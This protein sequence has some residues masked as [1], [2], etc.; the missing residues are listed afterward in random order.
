MMCDDNDDSG[1]VKKVLKSRGIINPDDI[2]KFLNPSV[3]ENMPD[4]SVLAGM[5]VA[6]K[7]VA[8]AIINNEKIAIFGDYDVDGITSTAILI[9]YLRALGADPVW[10]LPSRDGE[11]YGLN[12]DSVEK[13]ASDG[14]RILITVDC[15]I[16]S[17]AEVAR[18]RE[19]GMKVVITDH[20]S[21]DKDLPDANAIVN[22]KQINDN[23]GLT[24]LAGVGVA[25][26]F[27]VALN[28]EIK[29][30]KPEIDINL[31][32]YLDL[33]AIGTI[34]DTCPLVGLNRAFVVTGLKIIESKKNIGIAALMQIS[35]AKSASA[36]TI[37]FALGPRINAAGRLADPAPA[38]ELLLTDNIGTAGVLAAELDRQ[39][40]SRKN[41]ESGIMMA[42]L[43]IAEAH[44]KDGKFSLFL[45]GDNW[46]GGVM[47]IIAG[48][49]KEKYNMP[50]CVATVQD[51]EIN[52]SGRSTESIDLGAIIHEALAAG[53]LTEGG[54]H[55]AAAGFSMPAN[56][57]NAF[58]EFLEKR[59]REITGN[60]NPKP[61]III[62]ARIDAG[63]A[64]LDL[65]REMAT[66]APFGQANPEP[67]LCLYGCELA[68]ATTM[69]NGSHIRGAVRTSN[70][71]N[72]NFV[73]FNMTTGPIG[74]FLLD[75]TNI[76]VKIM[77]AG[78]LT[79][80]EF[81]GRTTAQFMLE[82]IAV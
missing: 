78:R 30:S 23:S 25:F 26:M 57:A 20:H 60:E 7:I 12:I 79:E 6:T 73:G 82:D 19:L 36:Y 17:V 15:G 56:N 13:F 64:G 46:H 54:G 61:K 59:V 1:I 9:K 77:I 48:R 53:I 44:H 58:H 66:L 81:N 39:N 10:H 16:S 27:L 51:G 40:K 34:C 35:G 29:K 76:G 8:D 21:P 65:C 4:P 67:T 70:G 49:I 5:D 71:T 42:A 68:F 41:I 62:D 32:E 22:P 50:T 38:L 33:V 55:A 80:N 18:A 75:E 24:Y 14:V 52:G 72:L 69:G 37:G 43:E 74:N 28:R 63:G 11:G 45:C 2:Q 3:R 31:L 47:G